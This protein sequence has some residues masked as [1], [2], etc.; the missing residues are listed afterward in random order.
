MDARRREDD[1]LDKI[2]ALVRA[3]DSTLR[4]MDA[5]QEAQPELEPIL[6]DL[7]LTLGA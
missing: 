5:W 7:R 3:R 6:D 1:L 4:Q 2:S